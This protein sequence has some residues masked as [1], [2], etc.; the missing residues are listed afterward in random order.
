MGAVHVG[1]MTWVRS[2]A[3]GHPQHQASYIQLTGHQHRRITILNAAQTFD[4]FFKKKP[5]NSPRPQWVNFIPSACSGYISSLYVCKYRSR[6]CQVIWI[7][8]HKT[9]HF[10]LINWYFMFIMSLW[11][12]LVQWVSPSLVSKGH[13]KPNSIYL[14]QHFKVILRNIPNPGFQTSI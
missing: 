5:N 2:Q 3:P 10:L 9:S 12:S 4:V 11:F 6:I 7:L 13:N 1:W 8:A 14:L